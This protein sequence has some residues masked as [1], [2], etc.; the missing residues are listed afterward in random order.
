[1]ASHRIKLD[2]FHYK[3]NKAH[4]P[5][6]TV[7]PGDDVVFEINEVTSGQI[8]EN[9]PVDAVKNL[10]IAKLYPMAGPVF[11][12]GAKA[13]DTLTVEVL[14]VVPGDWGW[15]AIVNGLG[16]LEEFQEPYLYLW[17]L[18]KRK[19][20]DFEK[21]IKIPLRPFCGTMGV[22][23]PEEGSF[24]V[25]P[26]GKNG[27]NMDIRHLVAGSTLELPVYVDGALFSTSD[28]HAAMGDGEVC[29][30][31]IECPGTARFRFGV[32]KDSKLAWPRFFSR[33]DEKA[34]NGYYTATGIGPDLMAVTKESVRNMIAHLTKTYGLTKEEAYV[35]CSVAA[36][37]KIHEIVDQPNWVVG[38]TISLDI[39]PN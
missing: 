35:L 10:D 19:F 3:W 21:G 12:E 27:G 6:L 31:A 16:L 23:L 32:K 33:G 15:S 38:T 7:M 34:K 25:L 29:V 5:A 20:A 30:T 13:G 9:S 37:V 17:N 24:E 26:P 18:R 39:F 36:D 28:L 8:T 2:T 4:K 1:V 11:V 22:A 14:D